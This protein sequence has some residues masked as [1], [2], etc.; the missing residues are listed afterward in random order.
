MKPALPQR[1]SPA[2]ADA[3]IVLVSTFDT[4]C[5]LVKAADFERSCAELIAAGHVLER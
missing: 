1:S 2:H 3:G 5:L 4:D